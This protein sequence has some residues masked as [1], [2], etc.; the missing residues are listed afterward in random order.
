LCPP[1][2]YKQSCS[3]SFNTSDWGE[4]FFIGT[5][6][7]DVCKDRDGTISNECTRSDTI[8]KSVFGYLPQDFFENPYYSYDN[9]DGNLVLN[10]RCFKE[11]SNYYKNPQK[12]KTWVSKH[13]HDYANLKRQCGDI[14]PLNE[15]QPFLNITCNEE[16][17]NLNKDRNGYKKWSSKHEDKVNNF[18][19][20]CPG[21]QDAFT[22]ISTDT[23]GAL[24]PIFDDLIK[25]NKQD[26]IDD[27]VEGRRTG[28]SASI[29]S[30]DGLFSS[31]KKWMLYLGEDG[32]ITIYNPETNTVFKTLQNLSI[33][34]AL[35]QGPFKLTMSPTGYMNLNDK[36][37]KAVLA[38]GYGFNSPEGRSFSRPFKLKLNDD[39]KLCIFH[40][41]IGFADS[42]PG[43]YEYGKTSF[44]LN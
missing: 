35:F 25:K 13:F 19:Y 1:G 14:V 31:N 44:C 33:N 16:L 9:I 22:G 32:E 42:S 6:N 7:K 36:N 2:S 20:L 37:N 27:R 23:S 17:T 5:C 29:S 39:G 21:F 40:C 41:M 8:Q 12:Y 38:L 3:V 10:K 24:K 30:G 18:F 4:N 26:F 11:K 43:C 34:K 28:V 15:I